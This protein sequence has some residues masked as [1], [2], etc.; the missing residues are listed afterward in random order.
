[1][2]PGDVIRE[3]GGKKIRGRKD[4]DELIAAAKIGDKLPIVVE[5]EGQFYKGEIVVTEKP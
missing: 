2:R 3:F 5:R 4:V 1:V